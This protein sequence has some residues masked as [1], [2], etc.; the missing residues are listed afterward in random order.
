MS[1]L[2]RNRETGP[3]VFK[4]TQY[5]LTWGGSIDPDGSAIRSI[6]DA[7]LEDPAFQNALLRGPLEIVP[8]DQQE[9]A[10]ASMQ[11]GAQ[12][13]RSVD[14]KRQADVMDSIQDV[15]GQ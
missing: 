8:E 14:E 15:T 11:E 4:N 1:V 6:P 13:A 7:L 5:D 12:A 10:F 2:V 3:T 9:A